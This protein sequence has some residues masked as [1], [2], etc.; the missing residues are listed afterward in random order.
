LRFLL[1]VHLL[2]LPNIGS[3]QARLG[4]IDSLK[5]VLA[6]P[7]ADTARANSLIELTVEYNAAD[8]LPQA[9]AVGQQALALCRRVPAPAKT[10]RVLNYLANVYDKL[11]EFAQALQ[12][13]QEALRL[14]DSLGRPNLAAYAQNGMGIL[15]FQEKEFSKS[16]AAYRQ[17]FYRYSALK[18]WPNTGNV[19]NNIG[20]VYLEMGR[21]DS[22]LCY[23]RQAQTVWQQTN[24]QRWLASTHTYLG[25]A[26]A[27]LQQY[28]SA[29]YYLR[30]AEIYQQANQEWFDLAYTHYQAGVVWQKQ[31][32]LPLAT[33]Q[34]KA[35]L[36]LARRLGI[37][38]LVRDAAALLGQLYDK[39]GQAKAAYQAQLL[40]SAYQDSLF[41]SDRVREFARLQLLNKELE[42]E[43]LALK[44]Q[45]QNR[46]LENNAR[47][48]SWQGIAIGAIT[49]ALGF[50]FWLAYIMFA[51]RQRLARLNQQL[52]FSQAKLSKAH[53][54]LKK[55]N[56]LLALQVN[57]Q[58][59]EVAAKTKV[60]DQYQFYNGHILR[61]PYARIR[62]LMVLWQMSN[63]PELR[64]EIYNLFQEEVAEL[65]LA[66][67]QINQILE[68]H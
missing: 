18:R 24:E 13:Y 14:A 2:C 65:G 36:T 61:A 15:F 38:I 34:A 12:S 8:S 33:D 7:L 60:I 10:A 28:D 11:G 20:E 3:A 68:D 56:D 22:A 31:A 32:N 51:R 35:A 17:A 9:V 64:E 66:I 26:F 23:F 21:A 62:G 25:R 46:A 16:L 45:Q 5:T 49:L 52:A 1:L 39:Q 42:N 4:A 30:Q 50:L 57:E 37:K 40:S 41:S 59:D 67:K 53:E 43:R 27:E 29:R 6:R 58:R 55:A 48:I 44:T 19:L 54:G 63:D 47:L